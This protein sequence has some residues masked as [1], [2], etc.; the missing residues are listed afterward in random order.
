MNSFIRNIVIQFREF[1]KN[2]TP[3]KRVSMTIATLV[4]AFSGLFMIFM[5]SGKEYQPLYTNIATDQLPVIM[6][7]LQA[8]NIAYKVEDGGKTILV[9]SSMVASTQMMIM[10][11]SG[12][13]K[14]GNV[15]SGLELFDKQDFGQTSYAQRINYQRALQGELIRAI[16][17]LDAVKQA[18]VLLAMPPKKTFLEESAPPTASVVLELHPGKSLSE[19]QVKGITY[20]ISSAVEGLES[21]KVTVVDSRGKVLSRPHNGESLVSS[22]LAEKKLKE[23]RELEE[24]IESILAKVV[25]QGKVI[26]KVD[27][28]LNQQAMN[29]VEESVDPDKTAILSQ[30][31]EDE[32]LDGSRTNPTGIPGARA[33]LPGAQDNGQVGFNQNVKKELKQTNYVVPK[34]IRNIKEAAGARTKLS[35]AVLV[36]G[37][38]AVSTND[39][40]EQT[41]KYSERT[42][43]EMAKLENII[44][45]T[46]GFDERRG[47]SLKLENIQFQKEDFSESEKLLTTLERKKLMNAL[48]KWTLLGLALTFFF[49]IVLR[50]FMRWVTDSFQDSVEDMLPRTI[51]E[52]EELQSVD[53]SLPG[54]SSAL[55]VLE[56]AL[57]PDKAESELL[58]ERIMSLM[59]KDEEK[60]AGAFS[61]WLVRRDQ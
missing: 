49:F 34:T 52:L 45:S 46:V 1:Y 58:K 28:T 42:P 41:E 14:I 60:S 13:S 9:P 27:V 50:P 44:R 15:G 35:V 37:N 40:G 23:Q 55:P 33:N 30:S 7:K 5:V 22:E 43:A 59:E 53:N 19:D 51:E 54:M 38:Y 36:D 57:D 61:L 32:S 29:A 2:L 11:E 4:V 25:G 21:E 18:K 17:T 26:A 31:G 8:K 12:G 56:E 20:L 6:Q 47:D 39:Q 10:V 24:K 16:T 3:T 48:L